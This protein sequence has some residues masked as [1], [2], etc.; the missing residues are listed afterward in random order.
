MYAFYIFFSV[1]Y[2]F[3]IHFQNKYQLGGFVH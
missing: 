3:Y 1:K 2:Q